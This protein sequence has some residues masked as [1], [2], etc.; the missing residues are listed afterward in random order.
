MLEKNPTD[1]TLHDCS[2]FS[3]AD[4]LCYK[5]NENMAKNSDGVPTRETILA[6]FLKVFELSHGQVVVYGFVVNHNIVLNQCA[7]CCNISAVGR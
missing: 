2:L 5:K 3:E 1:I 7:A 4:V 6:S